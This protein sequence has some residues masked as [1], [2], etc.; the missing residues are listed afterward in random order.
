MT[1]GPSI[2]DIKGAAQARIGDVL[3]AL[4]VAARPSSAGYISICNPMVKDRHP[5]FTIWTAG[6]AIGAWK[7]HRDDGPGGSRGDIIDLVSYL[8]GWWERPRKGRAEALRWLTATLDLERVPPEQLAADRARARREQAARVKQHD[9]A[10]AD[11]QARAF[12]LW[13]AATPL[14]IGSWADEYLRARSIYLDRLP[15]GPR[16]GE[17]TPSI[18]RELAAHRHSESGQEL[19]CLVAGCVDQAGRITAVHRTFLARDGHWKANV[20]P[21]KKVWPAFAGLVIPLWRGESRL[22]VRLAGA[23]GLRETLVLTEGIE[24]G[25]SAAL[26][27]PQFRTW[28]FISLGNLGNVTLPD[29]IDSVILHRQNEWENRQAVVAFDRGKAAL[30]RQGRPVVEVHA[31]HGKDLND[32]RAT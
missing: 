15:R 20:T 5:S 3:A 1:A 32:A 2:A 21:V 18:L 30:E 10:L 23:A 19:P 22:S 24:D 28:A 11:K 9:E 7:D 4:G 26:A 6:A 8:N 31:M 29:C 27:A 16:G 13:L 12:A 14:A 17:R 25:L